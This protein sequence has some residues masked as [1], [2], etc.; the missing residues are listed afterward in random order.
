MRKFGLE[1]KVDRPSLDNDAKDRID[2]WVR[3]S[4]K[5]APLTIFVVDAIKAYA[6]EMEARPP[7]A[8]R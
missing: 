7:F 8:R 6:D 3:T 1:A 5:P 2:A 4:R